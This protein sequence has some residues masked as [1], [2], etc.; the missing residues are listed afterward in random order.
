M[1]EEFEEKDRSRKDRLLKNKKRNLM[2]TELLDRK[3]PYKIKIVN[4]K[5]QTYK[6]KKLRVNDVANKEFDEYGDE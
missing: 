5:K 6:R 4:P 2:A 1:D 3:G